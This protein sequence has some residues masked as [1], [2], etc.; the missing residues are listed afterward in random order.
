MIFR[1]DHKY[2][3]LDDFMITLDL[4]SLTGQAVRNR[5]NLCLMLVFFHVDAEAADKANEL[6]VY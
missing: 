1:S 2:D 4:P 3:S 6:P 5:R